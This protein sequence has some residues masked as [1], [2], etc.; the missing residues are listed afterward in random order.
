MV[1]AAKF[2]YVIESRNALAQYDVALWSHYHSYQE[3]ASLPNSGKS[4]FLIY[5]MTGFYL[6]RF[7]GLQIN[8]GN[9]I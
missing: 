5:L 4:I 8:G 1:R 7:G 9:Q 6:D 2:M 3:N